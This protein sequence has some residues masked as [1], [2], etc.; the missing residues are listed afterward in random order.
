MKIGIDIDEVLA[1]FIEGVN[2]FYNRIHKTTFSFADY[3]FYDLEKTWGGSKERA[4]KIISDFY[5]SLDFENILPVEGSREAIQNLS[6]NHK[7]IA[8]TSRPLFT[9]NATEKWIKR[10]YKKSIEEIIFN[11]Q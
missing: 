1:K 11:G 7:L 8:L 4:I 9:K 2:V 10:N 6:A 5:K 3:K